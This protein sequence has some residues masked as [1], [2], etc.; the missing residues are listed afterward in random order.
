MSHPDKPR[1]HVK[2]ATLNRQVFVCNGKA[3]A[4]RGSADVKDALRADLN[5]RD[6]LFGKP[7][8]A[9]PDGSVVVT[10]C[11]SVGFCDCGPAVLVYPD[12]VWYQ[13]VT[14]AD[15]PQIV[16]EHLIEGRPVERLIGRRLP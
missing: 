15:V 1:R 12:G 10:D 8:K 5:A 4:A 11:G 9:N 2:D 6:L 14:P 7:E 16:Q 13:G 3:C